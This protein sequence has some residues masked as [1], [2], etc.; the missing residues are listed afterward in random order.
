MEIFG[1]SD[2]GKK[3]VSNQDSF[4]QKV[5]FQDMAWS[6]VCD[7]MGG[8]NAGDV[9]SKRAV[10]FV[11]EFLDK[12]LSKTSTDDEIR[13]IMYDALTLANEDIYNYAKENVER[14]ST[15]SHL[16]ATGHGSRLRNMW[17]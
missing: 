7:G 14:R 12:H 17:F 11:T 15:T 8:L 6:V 3:R 10:D 13:Q 5:V 4:A 9:A 2:I 16:M 1:K